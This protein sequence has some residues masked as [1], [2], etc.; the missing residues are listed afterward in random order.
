MKSKMDEIE[1]ICV[2]CNKPVEVNRELYD[3]YER[4]HWLCFHLEY[5]HE[6]DP[7]RPCNDPSCIWWQLEVY[8]NKLENMGVDSKEV[9]EQAIKERWK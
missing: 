1:K 9:L 5:E 2:K 3:V 4:M 7:D 8:K 6:G